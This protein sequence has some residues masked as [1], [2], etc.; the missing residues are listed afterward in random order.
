[1]GLRVEHLDTD[2]I[3]WEQLQDTFAQYTAIAGTAT[4]QPEASVAFRSWRASWRGHATLRSTSRSSSL[5]KGCSCSHDLRQGPSR[6]AGPRVW[7]GRSR[8]VGG[9]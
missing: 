4:V 8:G 5:E 6:G 1:M 7:T 2:V 3:R 9:R